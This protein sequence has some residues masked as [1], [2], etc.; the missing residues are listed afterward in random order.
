M[1]ATNADIFVE[2]MSYQKTMSTKPKKYLSYS[3]INL[4]HGNPSQY[5]LQYVLGHKPKPT[6]NM[7]YGKIGHKALANPNYDW[8]AALR[9]KKF[10]AGKELVMERA[11]KVY[12]KCK[13]RELEFSVMFEGIQLY[14]FIDGLAPGLIRE[15]KFSAPGVWKQEIVD[16]DMQIGFYWLVATLLGHKIKQAWLDHINTHSGAIVSFPTHRSKQELDGVKN[17]I[18]YAHEGITKGVFN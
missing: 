8:R 7:E 11:L 2:K 18:R 15:S 6:P 9:R 10:M 4:Y 1:G 5:Y 13:V 16:E 14:G 3:R 17:W 12:P